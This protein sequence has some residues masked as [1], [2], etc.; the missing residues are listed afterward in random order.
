MHEIAFAFTRDYSNAITT[1]FIWSVMVILCHCLHSTLRNV[2]LV[3]SCLSLIIQHIAT[4]MIFL[5]QFMLCCNLMLTYLTV[6]VTSSFFWYAK[7]IY[8]F[9]LAS[10]IWPMLCNTY[11]SN[12]IILKFTL[13]F[14]PFTLAIFS[15]L[16]TPTLTPYTRHTRHTHATHTPHTHPHT[17]THHTHH[18]THKYSLSIG[19]L[20]S[21]VLGLVNT[22][23]QRI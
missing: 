14:Y 3:L 6:P 13:Q 12:Y 7:K 15:V 21:V 10:I 22:I 17:H 16:R 2:F 9:L 19:L 18:T 23:S 4:I 5:V 11:H 1:M 20:W 8:F